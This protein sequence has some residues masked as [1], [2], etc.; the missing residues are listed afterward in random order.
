MN[1]NALIIERN[2]AL[3]VSNVYVAII[4][5]KFIIVDTS[6]TIIIPVWC[7]C[8]NSSRSCRNSLKNAPSDIPSIISV[9]YKNAGLDG[10]ISRGL[11]RNNAPDIKTIIT[12]TSK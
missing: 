10:I 2:M 3:S 7:L 12:T 9:A 6:T 4:V 5:I 8:V 11:I 1:T